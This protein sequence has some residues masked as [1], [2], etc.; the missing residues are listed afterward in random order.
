VLTL[1]ALS[2]MLPEL[3]YVVIDV[4]VPAA[5]C[6]V[7]VVTLE[8]VK[9]TS[10]SVGIGLFAMYISTTL[11]PAVVG[12][13]VGTAVGVAVGASLGAAVGEVVGA[14]VGASVGETVGVS[15]GALVCAVAL[16]QQWKLMRK[17]TLSVLL[18]LRTNSFVASASGDAVDAQ[19][20]GRS[21][22]KNSWSSAPSSSYT[23][24]RTVSLAEMHSVKVLL[25]SLH[26]TAVL[27]VC[28]LVLKHAVAHLLLGLSSL[29]SLVPQALGKN[30]VAYGSPGAGENKSPS[31]G[32]SPVALRSVAVICRLLHCPR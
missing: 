25:L 32:G 14:A 31:I 9:T 30:T 2:M 6:F 4:L 21:A 8:I 7:G 13:L 23:H 3:S 24:T 16:S 1:D 10:V 22:V 17:V 20:I 11:P 26:S 27:S 18:P 29:H 28:V 12:V 15:E 5:S 19:S